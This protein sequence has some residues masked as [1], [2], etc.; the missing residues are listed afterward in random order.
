MSFYDR[1]SRFPTPDH[2][3]TDYNSALMILKSLAS[4]GPAVNGE[5]RAKHFVE[6]GLQRAQILGEIYKITGLVAYKL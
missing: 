3:A 1:A 2:R 4:V 5:V 6:P